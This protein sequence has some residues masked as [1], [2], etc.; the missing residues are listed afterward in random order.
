M[1]QHGPGH[2]KINQAKRYEAGGE[3]LTIREW[4]KRWGVSP[5]TMRDRIDYR[6]KQGWTLEDA[7]LTPGRAG[8]K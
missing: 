4:A 5:D 1:K 8:K 3:S 6:L 7:L 2:F